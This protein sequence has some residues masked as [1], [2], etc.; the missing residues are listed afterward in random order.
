MANYVVSDTNLTAV[1][2]AIRTKGGT[3]EQLEFPDDFVSAIGD[4]QTGGG[5]SV[6]VEPLSVTENGTYTAPTGKAYSPVSVSVSGGGTTPV[7][8]TGAV[9]FLDYDG[10]VVATYSAAD[11][12]NLSALPSQ[13]THTGLTGQGWNWTLADAKTYVQAYGA[14]DIGCN[15]VTTDGKTRLYIEIEEGTPSNRM[16]FYVRCRPTVAA[17]VTIDWDDGTST[18]TDSTSSKNYEHT[19]ATPGHYVIKLSVT[20][21]TV[22]FVGSTS[23]S[24]FGA[25]S[26][27]Y[28]RSRIKKIEF[29]TGIHDTSGIGASAFYNCYS[30]SSVTIPSN[31]TSIGMSAFQYCYSLSSVTIPSSVTSIGAIAFYNCY[32]LSSITIPSNVTSIGTNAF[33]YCYSL[34][35]VTIPSNVTSIGTNA[36]NSCSGVGEYVLKPETPPTLSNVNTF[37]GIPSDCVIRVPSGK[38]TN[39]QTANIWSTWASKMVEST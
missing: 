1:A 24:I 10:T 17:G 7:D 20:S 25:I 31:V 21:G 34:S 30:L 26:N 6:T 16:T 39:Y 9:R 23:V 11:F 18:T 15:Y 4:I 2:N 35:S 3:S 19:Y 37:S 22:R 29:G 13:P 36:F 38:L 8:T 14:V 28:N 5:S 33:Q 12:A 32:S 27:T